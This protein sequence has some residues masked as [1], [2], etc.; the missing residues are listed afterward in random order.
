MFN[1]LEILFRLGSWVEI[2]YKVI[3]KNFDLVKIKIDKNKNINFVVFLGVFGF[4]EENIYS[5]FGNFL[6]LEET[7]FRDKCFKLSEDFMIVI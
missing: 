3:I 7:L 4:N 6:E 1:K 2:L 5:F